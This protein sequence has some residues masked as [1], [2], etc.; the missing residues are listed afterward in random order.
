VDGKALGKRKGGKVGENVDHIAT[1]KK[2][3]GAGE[4]DEEAFRRGGKEKKRPL[5][6]CVG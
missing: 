5:T 1:G 6:F 2:N 3:Q 4:R